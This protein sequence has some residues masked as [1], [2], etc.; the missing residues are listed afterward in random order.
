MKSRRKNIANRLIIMGFLTAYVFICGSVAAA[1]ESPVWPPQQRIPGYEANTWPPILIPDQN[2]TVHAF[3][4]QWLDG[5]GGPAV[6]AIVYNQWTADQ[7]WTPP[8]DVILSPFKSES[9]ILDAFLDPAGMVHLIFWGGDNTQAN[10][11]YAR[12]PLLEAGKAQSWSTPVLLAE[13]AGDPENGVFLAKDESSLS[14]IFS[15]QSGGNGLYVC[16]SK[17]DGNTWSQ[18]VLI[19][20]TD[21]PK[22]FVNELSSYRGDSGWYHVIWNEV[23]I[24]GQGRGIYYAKT[25]G[26]ELD[27]MGPVRLAEAEGGYGTNTP[28]VLEYHNEILA[29][30]NLGGKI[31][32]RSAEGEGLSWSSPR[33]VFSRHVGVNGAL[34]LVFDGNDELHMFFGQRITGSP[35]IHGMWHSVYRE[36]IWSEPEAVVSGPAINDPNVEKNFD[37]FEARSV[38]VQGNVLLVTW[39]TDP[40][41]KGNG[42]WYSYKTLD[43][44]ELPIVSP[45]MPS[46]L[47][48]STLISAA[49]TTSQ[50]PTSGSGSVV[51]SDVPNEKISPF[52][53]DSPALM[54]IVSVIPVVLLASVIIIKNIFTH[55]T[56]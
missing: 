28:A 4:S 3:S 9:R 24:G 8:N 6:R 27:W 15:G 36:N 42:V 44:P 22:N 34:S 2:R 43:I 23:T 18:P 38:A 5:G 19:F 10:V 35:D 56:R 47:S 50:F 21:D 41:L 13:K 45:E 31:W 40:G 33:Q 30:Y 14:V 52:L 12:A 7:G 54:L 20:Y 26:D 46:I 25:G 32:Q 48:T 51:M 29:F 53:S 16:S 37:P 49:E 39:R 17:D 55:F 1:Q 11:Y